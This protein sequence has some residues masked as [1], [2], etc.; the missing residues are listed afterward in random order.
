MKIKIENGVT[1]ISTGD[2][3]GGKKNKHGH[4]GINFDKKLKKYR[5]E[6]NFKRKKYFLGYFEDVNEAIEERKEADRHVKNG[7]FEEW[8][9]FI[10]LEKKLK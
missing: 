3:I 1:I 5:S 10:R 7:D 6:I 4:V 2:P 9:R 8:I